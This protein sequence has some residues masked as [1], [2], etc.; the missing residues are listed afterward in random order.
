MEESL[1]KEF[2]ELRRKGV[3]VKGWWFKTRAKAILESTT[4]SATFK[5]SEGW[6]TRFKK[7]YHVS[8]R[9]PTN[10]AQK[11]PS[12]KEEAIQNFHQEIRAIQLPDGGD[13]PQEERFRLHQIASMDQTPLPFSLILL[14]VKLTIQPILLL[15]GFVVGR[16]GLTSGSALHNLQFL[17]MGSQG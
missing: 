17:P 15:C 12:E 3:K 5:F 11:A 1:H 2:L 8:F 4:P 10:T 13:G 14:V 7:R 9:R 16:L 6:F